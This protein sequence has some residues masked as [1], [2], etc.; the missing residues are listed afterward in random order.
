M[1]PVIAKTFGGLTPQYY[2]RHFFFGSA[3]AAFILFVL[4]KD[5]H[6]TQLGVIAW[7][8]VNTFLYPYSR[9]VYES[10]VGFIMGSN[11]F[12]LNAFVMLSVKAITIVVCWAA[13]V[14]VA[15]IGLLYL[16]V[17]HS[18]ANGTNEA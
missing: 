5:P 13:A 17:H 2:L 4:F 3:V 16:Y 18:R 11:V 15:P 8:V 7:V 1:H 12:F 9:F 10:V 6:P 14:F